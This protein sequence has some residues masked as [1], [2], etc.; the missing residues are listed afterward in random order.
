MFTIEESLNAYTSGVC[1]KCG[2]HILSGVKEPL[3]GAKQKTPMSIKSIKI[4]CGKCGETGT[5]TVNS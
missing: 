3:F 5:G 1:P 4:E 2:G